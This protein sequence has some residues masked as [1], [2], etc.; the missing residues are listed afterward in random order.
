MSTRGR[1]ARGRPPKTPL[2]SIRPRTNFLRKPKAYQNQGTPY[3]DASSRSSTPVSTPGTPTRGHGR[4]RSREAAQ[5]SRNFIHTLFDDDEVSRSSFDPE[6]RASDVLDD[7]DD[8]EREES[9]NSYVDNSD[10]DFSDN[11]FSTVNSSTSRRKIF[12]SRRPKTP[13]IP[14]DRELPPLILPTSSTD[15]LIPTEYLMQS[16]SI[17]EVL[18]H[19][20][21]ILRLSPFS[22]EDFCAAILSDEVC[23]LLSE[24]HITLLRALLREED[25]NNTAFGPSDLKDSINISLFFID[26][27]TW[28]EPVRAFLDSDRHPEHKPA[29]EALEMGEYPYVT[30]PE[31]LKV[32]K[33]LT[34]LFLATNHVREEIMNEGNIQYDD[35]CRNC[36]K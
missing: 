14:D 23:P 20:R 2:S 16:L 32:L 3:S 36:H 11:S 31:R 19:F 4:G 9:D 24:I 12:L 10:S 29:I 22:F 27:L 21:T 33:I 1:R 6:D 15:L 30:L 26:A 25:G 17:Y 28:P 7:L 18:R 5:K 8:Q 13:D 35:H 34:D